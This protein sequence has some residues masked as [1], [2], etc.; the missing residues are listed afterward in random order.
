MIS[1][2]QTDIGTSEFLTIDLLPE[3][4]IQLE[5]ENSIESRKNNGLSRMALFLDYWKKTIFRS[6]IFSALAL[7]SLITIYYAD[8]V[9]MVFGFPGTYIDSPTTALLTPCGI[10]SVDG[11]P[12]NPAYLITPARDLKQSALQWTPR[13]PPNAKIVKGFFATCS[14]LEALLASTLD[15]LYDFECIQ[16][17]FSYFPNLNQVRPVLCYAFNVL[18]LTFRATS[19]GIIPFYHPTVITSL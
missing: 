13:L 5:I 12:I 17:L 14:I 3:M 2:I 6:N 19:I 8:Y 10:R 11:N 18:I 7:N 1:R 16:L 4:P 9:P 15:C